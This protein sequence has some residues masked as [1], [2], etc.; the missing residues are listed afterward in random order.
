MHTTPDTIELRQ[1]DFQ[2]NGTGTMR[3]LIVEDDT[4]IA[5][6]LA[7]TLKASGYAVD[8]TSTLAF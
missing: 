4:A 5:T 7:A 1:T 6:G 8:V 3:V 2:A